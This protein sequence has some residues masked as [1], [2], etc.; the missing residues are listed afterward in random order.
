MELASTITLVIEPAVEAVVTLSN[1]GDPTNTGFG[2][3]EAAVMLN[4]KG[5]K[6]TETHAPFCG[7]LDEQPTMIVPAF[8][9]DTAPPIAEVPLPSTVSAAVKA[10]PPVPIAVSV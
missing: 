4:D 7:P 1:N 9:F 8:K 5:A 3:A 10:V 6:I 2:E